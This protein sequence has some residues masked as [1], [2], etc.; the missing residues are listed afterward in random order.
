M[1]LKHLFIAQF[2]ISL[3]NGASAVL[4]PMMWL[5]LYGFSTVSQETAATGQ[6]LGAGLLNYAIIAGFARNTP[7]SEARRAIVLGFFITHA[8]GFV[9]LTL[10]ILAGV[11]GAAG[12]MGA[13][14]YLILA[15]GYAYFLVK[16]EDS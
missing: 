7:E 16:K 4:A 1:K 13:G 6:A 12:W 8:I 5:T 10:S 2:V 3:I 15:L 11:M 9:I 14:L